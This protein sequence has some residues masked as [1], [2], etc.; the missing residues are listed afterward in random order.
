M[1]LIFQPPEHHL[2]NNQA[3]SVGGHLGPTWLPR[4][5]RRPPGG[6][7]PRS[8]ILDPPGDDFGGRGRF[9]WRFPGGTFER[10]LASFSL[11]SYHPRGLPK[12]SARRTKLTPGAS[13][14]HGKRRQQIVRACRNHEQANPGEPHNRLRRNAGLTNGGRRCAPAAHSADHRLR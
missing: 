10:F 14:E 13:P 6:W 3:I 2:Q 11:F 5:S 1:L 8:S 4:A 7:T 9:I 12:R